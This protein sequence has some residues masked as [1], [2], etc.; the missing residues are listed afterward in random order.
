M[1]YNY[2]VVNVSSSDRHVSPDILV[3]GQGS[4][5]E[6]R[7]ILAS[8]WAGASS[9]ARVNIS[10]S[11]GPYNLGYLEVVVCNIVEQYF[12]APAHGVVV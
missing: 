11:G 8:E 1:T 2:S 3:I 7:K 9:E 10:S 4:Y 12:I 6:C 5:L